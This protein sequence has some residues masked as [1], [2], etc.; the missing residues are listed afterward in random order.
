[1]NR[2]ALT[3]LCLFLVTVLCSASFG[4]GMATH[5]D[6]VGNLLTV[7]KGFLGGDDCEGSNCT[8]RSSDNTALKSLF[9][10][11][12]A[13]TTVNSQDTRQL[14]EGRPVGII[15][16]W[17]TS[18]VVVEKIQS[19]IREFGGIHAGTLRMT[20]SSID[21]NKI[22][23]LYRDL[24]IPRG[25]GPH[26]TIGP[27]HSISYLLADTFADGEDH[28]HSLKTVQ[29]LDVLY[30]LNKAGFVDRY[31][32]VVRKAQLFVVIAPRGVSRKEA[33]EIPGLSDPQMW[34][35]LTKAM[36]RFSV[37]VVAADDSGTAVAD[38]D[39][40]SSVS[41]GLVQWV[42]D[43]KDTLR[44]VST[45]DAIDFQ[46]GQ[47]SVGFALAELMRGKNGH[48]GLSRQA[49]KAFPNVRGE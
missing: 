47:A 11:D 28:P 49:D 22:A 42:R 4:M 2:W 39:L 12:R 14:L 27:A 17:E 15:A 24:S 26:P 9:Q 48:Y 35:E 1:M 23:G 8:S 38:G 21:R 19:Q 7:R 6:S 25:L 46:V 43:R 29:M 20:G 37:G 41:S 5:P 13:F 16:G 10:M 45:V 18:T 32:P 40:D 30:A 44:N 33:V 3:A 36:A 31:T 34:Y